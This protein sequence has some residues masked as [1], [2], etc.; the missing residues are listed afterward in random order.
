LKEKE[1]GEGGNCCSI[2]PS[3]MEWGKKGRGEKKGRCK[4]EG[5]GEKKPHSLSFYSEG[6]GEEKEQRGK[7]KERLVRL[8]TR[9]KERA[10][11]CLLLLKIT[12][13]KRVEGREGRGRREGKALLF[14]ATPGGERGRRGDILKEER[15]LHP[16]RVY[17]GEERTQEEK[18]K[19]PRLI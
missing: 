14:S 18:K 5:E 19:T 1:G 12:L 16:Q 10:T 6:G 8:L 3:S 7:R 17:R 11:V 4:K 9:K 15:S 2:F 13:Q